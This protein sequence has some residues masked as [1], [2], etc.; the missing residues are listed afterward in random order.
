VADETE[1]GSSRRSTT[2][3]RRGLRGASR[4]TNRPRPAGAPQNPL[5][6]CP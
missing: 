3:N 1:R 6:L 4:S 2:T 5:P